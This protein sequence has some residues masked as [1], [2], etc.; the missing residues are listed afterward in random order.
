LSVARSW[1]IRWV[2]QRLCG[3]KAKQKNIKKKKRLQK[4]NLNFK[5]EIQI[6]R[7]LTF[8]CDGL[9]SLKAVFKLSKRER[10]VYDSDLENI[11]SPLGQRVAGESRVHL[12]A[13]IIA[14]KTNP[15]AYEYTV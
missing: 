15:R 2:D 5:K 12:Q 9:K 13:I 11:S 14:P 6:F 8:V 1:F 4:R 3:L 7:S 10:S